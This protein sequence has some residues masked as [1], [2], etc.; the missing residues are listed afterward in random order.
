MNVN[1]I[2]E[3]LP[4]LLSF[5]EGK[6]GT[7]VTRELQK[8]CG[9]DLAD[10]AVYLALEAAVREGWVEKEHGKYFKVGSGRRIKSEAAMSEPKFGG[11]AVTA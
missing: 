8:A 3:K 6:R 7:V 11:K 4:S 9:V 5:N 1:E 2:V 10:A